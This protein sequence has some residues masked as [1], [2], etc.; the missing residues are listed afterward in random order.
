MDN[1]YSSKRTSNFDEEPF[2]VFLLSCFTAN[3]DPTNGS[4]SA[5]ALHFEDKIQDSVSNV[6]R[7]TGYEG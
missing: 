5:D 6:H 3:L 7:L 2:G 4:D 1:C